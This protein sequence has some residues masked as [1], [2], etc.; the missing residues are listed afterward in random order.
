M[1][2]TWSILTGLRGTKI[3]GSIR[4]TLVIYL[5]PLYGWLC[6]ASLPLSFL[7]PHVLGRGFPKATLLLPHAASLAQL[8]RQFFSIAVVWKAH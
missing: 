2:M 1:S 6:L 3:T 7:L 4:Y 8:L 5:L